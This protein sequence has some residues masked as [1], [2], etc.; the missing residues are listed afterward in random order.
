MGSCDIS[1]RETRGMCAKEDIIDGLWKAERSYDCRV[2]GLLEPR[3]GADAHQPT[4][5][6]GFRARLTAGVRVR[7]LTAQGIVLEENPS[8]NNGMRTMQ[9]ASGVGNLW[10]PKPVKQRVAVAQ[11]RVADR[12]SPAPEAAARNRGVQRREAG[13]VQGG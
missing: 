10:G 6:S 11:P 9:R 8:M 5:R 4:L 1:L 2:S 13:G 3:T 7:P 12:P